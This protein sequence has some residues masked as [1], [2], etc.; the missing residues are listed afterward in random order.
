MA[1]AVNFTEEVKGDY[2]ELHGRKFTIADGTY[3]GA[4]VG[5]TM[6]GMNNEKAKVALL[7]KDM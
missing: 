5:R 1:S 3:I 7:K 2:L 4:P 6:P